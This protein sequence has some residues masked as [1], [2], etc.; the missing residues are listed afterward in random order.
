MPR[1]RTVSRVRLRNARP[2]LPCSPIIILSL[3][4]SIS[5]H[6][7]HINAIRPASAREDVDEHL[8]IWQFY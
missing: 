2:D 6:S 3:I 4:V 1:G 5:R 8:L 7:A